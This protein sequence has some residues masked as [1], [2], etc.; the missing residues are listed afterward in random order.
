MAK[1]IGAFLQLLEIN[2]PKIPQ[3]LVHSL[4]LQ[5]PGSN[6]EISDF[7]FLGVKAAYSSCRRWLPKAVGLIIGCGAR[8]HHSHNFAPSLNLR[9]V[10]E[11]WE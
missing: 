10:H 9:D 5:G 1:L 11:I 7:T 8:F 2:V 3:C 4:F 6:S